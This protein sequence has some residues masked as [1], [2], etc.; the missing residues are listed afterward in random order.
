MD[1]SKKPGDKI[2]KIGQLINSENP[3]ISIITPYYNGG[4]TLMETANAVFSQT[5]PYFEW[6]IVDDGSKDKESLEKLKEIE[7]MDNRVVVYHKENGGPS[8]ARDYGI[9]KSNKDSKY[10]FFLDCDD[11]PDKT[12]LEC[13][14]W[15]LE[16]HS[17]ASF[18]YTTMVNFGDREFIWEQYLTV[19]KEKE[20]NLICIASMVKKEDLIEVGCFGIKEKAMYEDWNL[21]LKLLEKGK[22]PIR[23][24]APIFWY[25][26]SNTGEL[27]RANKN[28]EQAMKYINETASKITNDVE[29]IQFPRE[30]NKYDTVKIHKDMILPKYQKNGK[31]KI[32]FIFP[33]MVTGGADFFNLDLIKRLDKNKFES[34]VLTTTP[35]DNPI[36]QDFEMVCNEVY[37]MSTFLDRS[38]YINFVDYIIESRKIDL[39]FVSN[40]HY[41]YYM[42]PFIKA[43]YPNIPCIDYIHSIDLAD[44]RSGFGRC[45]KDVDYC[46]DK[47]YCCNN[48]T[49]KQ[50]I[51]DFNKN[52]VETIYIGTDSEK[53]DPVKYDKNK[54]KDK[55]NIP[56]NKKIIS[57][58][59]RLSE[60][61]RPEMFV[62][63]CKRLHYNN[64]NLY[65]VIA[66]D[67]YLYNSVNSKITDDFIMLGMIKE[68]AEIYAISDITVNCS[69][70][71]GLA[72]TSYESLSMGVPVVSTDVGGQTELIDENVGGVVHYNKNANKTIY[73]NEIDEYVKQVERVL[74]NL[75]EISKNCRNK[76]EDAFTLNSMAD[77]FSN[78][79]ENYIES[80]GKK[81]V[82]STDSGYT[83]YNLALETLYQ[84]YYFYC[85]TYIENK[86]GIVYDQNLGIKKHGK[87]YKFKVRVGRV[88][89]R[90]HAKKEAI[91]IFNVLRTLYQIIH[92]F[93]YFVKFL[94]LSIPA[95]F[96]LIYKLLTRNKRGVKIEK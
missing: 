73:N 95:V 10:I 87:L 83:E 67:G 29:P 86:F 60:E 1:Y 74:K 84:D 52:N 19:E 23:V 18:A 14:Y 75:D 92:N 58:I 78:I 32:L 96:V 48:F 64:P 13:L 33:W 51:N 15:T 85:K 26:T 89:D 28:K 47:T 71:E 43:K 59:A 79:F 5:Y 39:V 16:T 90:A 77:K 2:E 94:I 6:I 12:M 37:D 25:R 30:A 81:V 68:T 42:L 4:K 20:D 35:N 76:I 9:E 66:G 53:F 38:D 55:Y 31:K 45:S 69:S 41:G 56:K 70:L 22:I 40:S 11:I 46:L 72:L 93:I 54:L 63:I 36:R 50:L 65:F 44:P 34:I 91:I 3:V 21:W 82:I 17:E 57:F 7:K 8:V 24:N 62:E 88:L 80:N 27:S 61:K 49:K